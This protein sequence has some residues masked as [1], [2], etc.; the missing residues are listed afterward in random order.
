MGG[1][2]SRYGRSGSANG[3]P[4]QYRASGTGFSH[5]DDVENRGFRTQTIASRREPT[6]NSPTRWRFRL[7]SPGTVYDR[8]Q[9]CRSRGRRAVRL[10]WTVLAC[11]PLRYAG[12]DASKW[13]QTKDLIDRE[14][15]IRIESDSGEAS[16][17]GFTLK[18]TYNPS[19]QTLQIQCSDKPFLVPCVVVNDRIKGMAEKLQVSPV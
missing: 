19:E 5:P 14:Y 13:A 10:G 7:P 6:K 11:N 9:R 15:G 17:K 4:R 1:A 3:T 12:V 8:L 18:W 2:P 16:K